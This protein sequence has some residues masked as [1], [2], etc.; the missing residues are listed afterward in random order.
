MT[1]VLA[2]GGPVP[3]RTSHG[4]EGGGGWSVD[5]ARRWV[6]VE[7]QNR[8]KREDGM[9]PT[10]SAEAEPSRGSYTYGSPVSG[11]A[12]NE[13]ERRRREWPSPGLV[14]VGRGERRERLPGYLVHKKQQLP[15]E[16]PYGPRHIFT[17]GP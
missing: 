2:R 4:G 8:F 17:V 5:E 12:I 1:S 10:C 13:D 7:T 6:P 14:V 16:A 11:L 3:K 9:G 15:I